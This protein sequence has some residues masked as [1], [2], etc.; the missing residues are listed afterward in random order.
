MGDNTILLPKIPQ[1]QAFE[2]FLKLVTESPIK[3]RS[4]SDGQEF[5]KNL[6]RL[7]RR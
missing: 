5:V 3:T 4:F 1:T 2:R 7:H 6:F